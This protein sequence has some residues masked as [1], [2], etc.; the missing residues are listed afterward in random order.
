MECDEQVAAVCASTAGQYGQRCL[1][2]C[3]SDSNER[4]VIFH[5]SDESNG[6]MSSSLRPFQEHMRL[7]PGVQHDAQDLVTTSTFDSLVASLPKGLLPDMNIVTI[8]AQGMEYEILL[9]MRS[10]LQHF[11][12]VIVEVSHVPVCK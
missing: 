5:V 7:F 3:L 10:A 12:V 1:H 2:A 8:D 11:D 9:G 4:N 6:G